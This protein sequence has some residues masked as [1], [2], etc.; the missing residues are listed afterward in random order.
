MGAF[1]THV[2]DIISMGDLLRL[3][4]RRGPSLLDA[5]RQDGETMRSEGAVINVNIEYSNEAKFDPF[6]QS[7]PSYVISANFLPMK[8][9]KIVYEAV[10]GARGAGGG[11]RIVHDVHGL[12]FVMTVTG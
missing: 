5:R 11:D 12:L 7:Q 9:Y 1:S 3:A 2:G 6:G 4:D 10:H 8:Q